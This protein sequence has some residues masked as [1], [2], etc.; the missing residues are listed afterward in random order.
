MVDQ[1]IRRDAF[2]QFHIRRRRFLKWLIRAAFALFA[3]AFAIPALALKALKIASSNVASGDEL[4]YAT[5]NRAG[6]PISVADLPAGT[7]VH[8]FPKGKSNNPNA[9]IELVHLPAKDNPSVVAYS[10]I[11]THLGCTVTD[12]LNAQGDIH[13]PCHGSIFNPADHAAVVRGPAVRPLPGLP[14][15]VGPDGSVTATGTFDGPIGPQ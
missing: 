2:A 3:L 5:G 8:A 4:V 15:E 6:D 13:C 14:V 7:A 11:C 1:P 10:A 12:T 9:L